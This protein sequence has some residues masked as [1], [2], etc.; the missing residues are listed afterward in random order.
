MD[1]YIYRFVQYMCV[2]AFWVYEYVDAV[3]AVVSMVFVFGF[4]N[5]FTTACVNVV[6]SLYFYITSLVV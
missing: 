3:S 1:S 4:C 6:V 2:H 5:L